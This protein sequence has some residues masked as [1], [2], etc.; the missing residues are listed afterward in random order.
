M[1]H[2]LNR[3]RSDIRISARADDHAQGFLAV[4]P[5]ILRFSKGHRHEKKMSVD[6]EVSMAKRMSVDM[7]RSMQAPCIILF[8]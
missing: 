7:K 1:D 6:I 2:L 5:S 4:R 3:A 8:G